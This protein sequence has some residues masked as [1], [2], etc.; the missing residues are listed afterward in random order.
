MRGLALALLT[1][2]V[3]AWGG[4]YFQMA[5]VM[6]GGQNRYWLG[7]EWGTVGFAI[8]DLRVSN[9]WEWKHVQVPAY[10][11]HYLGDYERNKYHFAGFAFNPSRGP[12]RSSGWST[13]IPLWFPTLLFALLLWLVWRKT[14]PKYNGRG[15]PVEAAGKEATK[16]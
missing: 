2:C 5:Y 7:I 8:S 15:F 11:V 3:V 1:L 14:R 4:S 9:G 6:Y 12:L 16:P 10:G 13:L